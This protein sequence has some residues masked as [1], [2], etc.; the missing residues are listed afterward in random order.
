MSLLTH[1]LLVGLMSLLLSSEQIKRVEGG[2]CS[3]DNPLKRE[4]PCNG[5]GE[6]NTKYGICVCDS[7]WSGFNCSEPDSP[8]ASE[9]HLNWPAGTF[10]DGY[11]G[12]N[13]PDFVTCSWFIR[14]TFNTAPTQ[15]AD[16]AE[17]PGAA[18]TQAAI[19]THDN[20]DDLPT[21]YVF[22]VVLLFT[23]IN[24]EVRADAHKHPNAFKHARARAHTHTHTHAHT[25]EGFD[26]VFVYEGRSTD[27]KDLLAAFSGDY[28]RRDNAGKTFLPQVV[29]SRGSKGVTVQFV[30]DLSF[31]R[32]GF[33]CTYTTALEE[34]WVRNF[35]ESALN[36]QL[37]YNNVAENVCRGGACSDLG[38]LINAARVQTAHGLRATSTCFPS[39]TAQEASVSLDSVDTR[40]DPVLVAPARPALVTCAGIH[41]AFA[42]MCIDNLLP[43]PVLHTARVQALMCI[44]T[45]VWTQS[46]GCA[47]MCTCIDLSLL[48]PPRAYKPG[49]Q[50][51]M[52]IP[53]CERVHM[54]AVHAASS[55]SSSCSCRRWGE[56]RRIGGAG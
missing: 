9:T 12:I 50:A 54:C 23:E 55:G 7:G 26:W 51:C 53:I 25:Q 38:P 17:Q 43:Q 56:C 36:S 21:L 32:S 14:S 30:S 1:G 6:C 19:V 2:T 29:T 31:G 20:A 35:D 40:G 11:F 41:V 34:S 47:L 44:C 3:P 33:R 15:S 27:T 52:E 45:D 49:C 5:H 8:C 4:V 18:D 37:L 10:T 16:R 48:L 42:S 24:L 28:P 46:C 39:P 13:Y 22:P